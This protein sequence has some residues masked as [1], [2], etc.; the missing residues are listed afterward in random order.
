[1]GTY[2]PSEYRT[3]LKPIF[4]T[5]C[6]DYGVMSAMQQAFAALNLEPENI[7]LVSGIGCSSRMP[8]FFRT[9]GFHTVHGRPLPAAMGVKLA[10]SN[11]T[12]LV[13]A[14]DGDAYAIGGGHFIH[15]ARRNPNITY[16]VMDNRIYGL[17]KGQFSPTSPE[18][19]RTGSSPYGVIEEPL[20][21]LA[22]AISYGASF[23]ARGY[24]GKINLLAELFIKAIRHPGFAFIDVL[25]PCATFYDTYKI[26]APRI[27]DIPATHN[28]EDKLAAFEL[29][30]ETERIYLGIFYQIKRPTL[31]DKI[32]SIRQQAQKD[33]KGTIAKLFERLK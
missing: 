20:N 15:A 7:V 5:G 27:V 8:D 1:M 30:Q 19:L 3:N 22:M 31:E 12:V 24:A 4:C 18:K 14:G 11:L 13:T 10:N 23:I 32:N 28:V 6:G 16:I 9:Y 17:T 2:N 21:P 33:G 26:I 25:S 29:T